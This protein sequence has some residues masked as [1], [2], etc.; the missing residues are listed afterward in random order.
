MII[1]QNTA[2]NCTKNKKVIFLE[3]LANV[4]PFRLSLSLKPYNYSCIQ[5][6]FKYVYS[7]NK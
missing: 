3:L 2:L 4:G 1:L 7:F 5:W 6:S